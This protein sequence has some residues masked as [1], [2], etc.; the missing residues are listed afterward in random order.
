[1]SDPHTPTKDIASKGLLGQVLYSSLA[2]KLSRI[3]PFSWLTRWVAYRLARSQVANSN[4]P[5]KSEVVIRE[6][7]LQDALDG[8]VRDVVE[9]LGFTGALVATFDDGEV[10]TVKA[11]HFDPVIMSSEQI[12]RWEKQASDLVN[13][14]IS[15]TNPAVA[16]VYIHRKEYQK[17]LGVRAAQARRSIISNDLF[18]LFTPIAPDSIHEFIKGAQ[19]AL[20]IQQV[21][22]IPF[23]IKASSNVLTAESAG[24]DEKNKGEFVGSLFAIK[25]GEITSQD[26]QVLE[27]F[28][29]YVASFILSERRRLQVEIIEKLI[30]DIQKSLS[31]EQDVLDS[32]VKG[33]VDD[34]GYVGAMVALYNEGNDA[35]VVRA[36][37][38]GNNFT[39]GQLHQ[40]EQ[41]ISNLTGKT[42]SLTNPEI[43]R[44]H[45]NQDDHKNNLGVK[46]ART[47]NPVISRD[48]FNLF[49]PIVPDSSHGF[50]TGI[51]NGLGINQVIAVPFFLETKHEDAALSN[52]LMGV[53]LAA[54]RSHEIPT[55][56]IDI[57][58]AFGKQAAAGIGNAVLYENLQELYKRAEDRRKAAEIFGKMA[59]TASASVHALKNHLAVVKG[60]LQ[61][62]KLTSPE[63]GTMTESALKRV[64]E[65]VTLI[66]SFHEPAKLQTDTLVDVNACI[67]RA[68]ERTVGIHT[69]WITMDLERDLHVQTLPEILTEAFKVIIKNAEEALSDKSIPEESRSLEITS[70]RE[71]DMIEISIKDNGIGIDRDNMEKIFELRYSTKESR[72]G[73]GLFWTKDFVE[74]LGGNITVESE[75][76][77]GT[78]FIIHLPVV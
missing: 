26:I 48:M 72:L 34:L 77:K 11:S 8:I 20:G 37:Y 78:T 68:V 6:N 39:A 47:G 44:V 36:V 76:G 52:K 21:I 71:G 74:G 75:V 19:Q 54:S 64:N 41:Q 57:L 56:E 51:Q 14:P 32:I 16:R 35:L 62:L 1:M 65:M 43:A 67:H 53:L 5:P 23:F 7:S 70:R 55:W 73:F 28:A 61:L 42:L 45:L 18:D 10:L 49:T 12:R 13:K 22:T 9:I 27:T 58:N 40:W 46:A 66:E 59:F 69:S 25:Q 60:N 63:N 50:I 30:L 15:L 33:M 31:C 2:G 4:V 24:Y 29:Q 17:N 3:P 38:A